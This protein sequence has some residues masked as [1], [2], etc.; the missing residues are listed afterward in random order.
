MKLGYALRS[1]II[2]APSQSEEDNVQDAEGVEL[3][4]QNLQCPH[5]ANARLQLRGQLKYS[6]FQQQLKAPIDSSAIDNPALQRKRGDDKGEGTSKGRQIHTLAYVLK[7]Y[8]T[9]YSDP[10]N[11][12]ALSIATNSEKAKRL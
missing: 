5:C 2:T 3:T 4:N 10:N 11:L 12:K 6:K 8:H 7:A 1:L 9:Y